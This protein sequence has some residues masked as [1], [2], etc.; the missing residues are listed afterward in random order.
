[1]IMVPKTNALPLGYTAITGTILSKKKQ[2]VKWK[3]QCHY[4]HIIRK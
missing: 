4:L 1:M 2:K 3:N